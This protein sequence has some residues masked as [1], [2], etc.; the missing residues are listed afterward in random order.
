MQATIKELNTLMK[1]RLVTWTLD[2]A[3]YSKY[4]ARPGLHIILVGF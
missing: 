2:Q 3:L 4:Q 1:A